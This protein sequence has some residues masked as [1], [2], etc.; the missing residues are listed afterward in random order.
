MN[1]TG[2]AYEAAIHCP[3]CAKERFG[4]IGS[5]TKD[6]EGNPVT[7]VFDTAETDGRQSCDDCGEDIETVILMIDVAKCPTCRGD[8]TLNTTESFFYLQPKIINKIAYIDPDKDNHWNGIE[9]ATW[10]CSS[11]NTD[12]PC[13]IPVK[14]RVL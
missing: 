2:Y 14:F 13:E 12:E 7:T 1:I 5:D 11:C 6:R 8:L 4:E 10:S 3:R 9:K